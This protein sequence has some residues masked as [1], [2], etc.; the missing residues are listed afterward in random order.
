M[1][2]GGPRAGAGRPKGAQNKVTQSL[3]EAIK[4]SFDRVGGVEYLTRVAQEDPR[5]Y[6]TVVGKVIPAEL[7][8]TV[9]GSMA[10]TILSGIDSPPGG[11]DGDSDGDE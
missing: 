10:L 9:D 4:E 1:P 8:A 6:L 7:N 2:K 5:T 11:G 3:R